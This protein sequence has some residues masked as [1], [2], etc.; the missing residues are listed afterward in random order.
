MLGEVRLWL[1]LNILLRVVFGSVRVLP[2][3]ALIVIPVLHQVR[4]QSRL[5]LR[6]TLAHQ[7][8]LALP[9]QELFFLFFNINLMPGIIL[10]NLLVIKSF[11]AVCLS[12]S[13]VFG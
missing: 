2:T 13:N 11:W 4:R 12:I 8:F 7:S 5:L 1:L 10:D 6:L 3:G 9:V